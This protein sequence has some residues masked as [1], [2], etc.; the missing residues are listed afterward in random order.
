MDASNQFEGGNSQPSERP[1]EPL[2]AKP[3]E[4][5]AIRV[6]C[7]ECGGS[8]RVVLLTNYCPCISCGGAGWLVIAPGEYAGDGTSMGQFLSHSCLKCLIDLPGGFWA[9][10]RKDLGD[11]GLGALKSSACPIFEGKSQKMGHFGTW[12]MVRTK[13]GREMMRNDA[14]IGAGP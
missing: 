9:K 12:A 3:H 2:S 4:P 13:L 7:F 6:A 8:G 11:K 10:R 5:A 14:R 1:G